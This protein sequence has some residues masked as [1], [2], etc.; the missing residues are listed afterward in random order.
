MDRRFVLVTP[1]RWFSHPLTTLAFGIF[2]F[3]TGAIAVSLVYAGIVGGILLVIA[4]ISYWRDR[5][6]HS[7]FVELLPGHIHIAWS[8]YK[9][10]VPRSNVE[11]FAYRPASHGADGIFAGFRWRPRA[12]HIELKLRTPVFLSFTTLGGNWWAKS[13]PLE[14]EDPERLELALEEWLKLAPQ[15]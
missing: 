12:A 3:V 11:A 13:V 15:P 5:R 4:V 10:D 1:Q 9:Q 8:G 7:N 2:F 6:L 14:V